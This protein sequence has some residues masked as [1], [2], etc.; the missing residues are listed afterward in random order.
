MN[1]SAF[2]NCAESS[3]SRIF[4]DCTVASR[5]RA[6]S[7][8]MLIR[9][10]FS[11]LAVLCLASAIGARGEELGSG[12]ASNGSCP[13]AGAPLSEM[14]S[15]P[16]WNGWGVNPS[17]H[18]FQPGEMAQLGA[19]D[20]PRLK[21]KWAFGFPGATRSVAQPTVVGGRVFIGSQGGKVYSLDAKSGCAYWEFDAGRTVRSAIVV[22]QNA[23]GWTAY[24][25]DQRA[26]VYAVDALTG[27]LL[28]KTRSDEH[29]AAVITGAPTLVGGVLFVP[30]S[31][32]EEVTGANP[33]YSCCSFRG[34]INA[35]EAA[36]GK[37]L[38]KSYTIPVEPKPTTTNSGGVQ[39]MGP[40]GAAVWSSPTFDAAKGMVYVTT[41]DNYSDPAT[42]TSDAILAFNAETGAFEWSRQMTAGDAYT[43]ACGS[44]RRTN[45]PA[46]SGPDFDFGSSAI[47]VDLAN[48]KRA[49]VAGQKSGVVTAVDPDRGGEI[50]WQRRIGKGSSMGGVQW[51]MATD[52]SKIYAAVSD[53][54][55]YAVTPGAAGAQP[56]AFNPAVVLRVDSRAGGGLHALKVDSGEEAWQTPHP[57]CN[58]VPGCSPAQSAA[59]TAIPGVVFSG[60]LDGH[61]RAYSAEDGRILWDVDTKGEYHT[62]NGVPAHGGSIDGAGAVVVG[63]MLYVTSGSAFVGTIPGNV[64]LAYSVDGQ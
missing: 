27:K 8:R 50:I 45:C 2:E 61:L 39:L 55:V 56:L 13:T 18:R 62:V 49:L 34:S 1:A 30:V 16:H 36:T 59:V 20:L 19:D 31:S 41:G 42:D 15:A 23:S 25:G 40:S 51:G 48:G 4:P 26:N 64:L 53:L 5:T 6:P 60:G 3:K 63:G 17:Q 22:G 24:F 58:D 54:K 43:V 46:D 7:A 37:L 21:L 12:P 33:G 10:L 44:P 14:A 35:F 47:L 38:W 28:W 32:F 9:I 52:G 57:G 11:L 29:S